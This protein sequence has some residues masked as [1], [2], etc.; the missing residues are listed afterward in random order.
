MT[1]HKTDDLNSLLNRLIAHPEQLDDV[2][3]TL[4]QKLDEARPKPRPR[5]ATSRPAVDDVDF[6]DNFPV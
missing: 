2:R 5:L 3:E 4:L 1:Q 6:F